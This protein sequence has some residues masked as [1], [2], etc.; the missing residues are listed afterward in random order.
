MSRP[1]RGFTL[2]ELLVVIAIIAI[3]IG[4]LLPAIQKVREASNRSKCMNHLR[5]MALALHNY[6]SDKGTLPPAEV[7]PA[8]ATVQVVLLPYLEQAALY[9]H[10]DLTSGTSILGGSGTSYTRVR[11]QDVPIYNCPS[12]MSTLRNSTYGRSNYFGNVGAT[13]NSQGLTASLAGI[14][15][16]RN[17]LLMGYFESPKAKITDVSDG[18]SN[19]AAF[20]EVKRTLKAGLTADNELGV[21]SS[22]TGWSDTAPTAAHCNAPMASATHYDYVGLQYFRGSVMWTAF[23]NHT[24]TPNKKGH[25]RCASTLRIAHLPAT[26]YHP[27]G[28]NV[29][30]TD[31]AVRFV[32]DTVELGTWKA[33]GTRAGGETVDPT[34]N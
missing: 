20:S 13:A 31:G 19:T 28:V 10:V 6:E 11:N 16:P 34:G 12:E 24:T 5:Q 32:A 23:Y 1:R 4:L 18:T 26:S 2:I 30:F 8:Q 17:L 21:H 33:M 29:A 15:S 14:F 22:T 3:L 25:W 9:G 27:G 7:Y